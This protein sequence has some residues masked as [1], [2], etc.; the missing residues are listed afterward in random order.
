MIPLK[1]I[2][3]GIYAY[4]QE[5]VIDFQKLTEAQLFGI[6][7][8]VGSGK[9][10]ILE[11]ITF[12][13]YGK[14]ERLG[15]QDNIRH[16]MKNLKS[17]QMFIRFEFLA[18]EDFVQEHCFEVA[19]DGRK[20]SATFKRVQKVKENDRWYQ[21]EL[22]AEKLI[23]LS[24]QNFRR[25][26]IIPQ[27][28]FQEFLQLG[29]TERTRM[30]REIFNLQRFELSQ[31]VKALI[32]KN[33]NHLANILGKLQQLGDIDSEMIAEKT[34]QFAAEKKTL[35]SL[36][37]QFDGLNKTALQLDKLRE[38][39]EKITLQEAKSAQ[40]NAQTADFQQ[41]ETRLTAHLDC[42]AQFK[43]LLEKSADLETQIRQATQELAEMKDREAAE[44]PRLEDRAH[45]FEKAQKDFLQ[46]DQWQQAADELQVLQRIRELTK[47][48]RLTAGE[49]AEVN[50]SFAEK[51]ARIDEKLQRQKKIIETVKQLKHDIPELE[52]LFQLQNWF[53]EA[54]LMDENIQ[55]Q[56][57]QLAEIRESQAGIQAQKTGRLMSEPLQFWSDS[58]TPDTP[59][60]DL[61]RDL[62]AETEQQQT[63]SEKLAEKIH[64]LRVQA[65]LETFANELQPGDPCPLCGATDHP[66]IMNIQN[67]SQ[68]LTTRAAEKKTLDARI[69][70]LREA[71]QF[72][73][74]LQDQQTTQEKLA[75]SAEAE[76]IKLRKKREA[77]RKK[78]QWK[79]FDPEN[80]TAVDEA[81]ETAREARSRLDEMAAEK[82]KLE[83]AIE[84]MRAETEQLSQKLSQLNL[85][86]TNAKTERETLLK[87]LR[88][89]KA[90]DYAIY[91]DAQ[92]KSAAAEFLEKY[93][94][95][96]Q[97]YRRIEREKTELQNFLSRLGGQIQ[98]A[99]QNLDAQQKALQKLEKEIQSELTASSFAD[100]KEV[101]QLLSLNLDAATERR[102]I[103]DFF[104]EK[105]AAETQLA[106][107]HSEIGDKKYNAE[108]HA[109]IQQELAQVS[110]QIDR[111]TR[112]IGSLERELSV[113]RENL[114]TRRSLEKEKTGLENR[115]RN[116]EILRKMFSSSGFVNFVSRIYLQNLCSAANERF[117]RL[118][119]Q[120]LQLELTGDNNFIV[121]DFL[122]GGK[123]RSVKTLSG[124]QT[125]QASLC[126]AL[127][128]ADNVRH[129]SKSAQ[130]FFF[131]DEGFGTLDRESLRLVFETLKSLRKENR[132]IGV[133]SHVE[134]M[135]DEIDVY[136]RIRNDEDKGS[137]ITASWEN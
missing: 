44:K 65:R 136:L 118:T 1:L 133:I 120:Q 113:A 95:V 125:F 89:I 9:S 22:N 19:L 6:F 96:E 27:G 80:P 121:R 3:K 25:T 117:R 4:Q 116:L 101:K 39:A 109:K 53:G 69:A 11:A 132:I 122:N 119:R 42:V 57:K 131:L 78:F 7:G 28:K 20:K 111:Q 48:E 17:D 124:G 93:A 72:F 106:Q 40:L 12:A 79:G 16:N 50:K 43:G 129:L 64:H 74:R 38:L 2:L 62:S 21:K 75:H 13:L 77:H 26:V 18:G 86:L 81:I 104:R 32:S 87:N 91:D 83:K 67:L 36:Q 55:Q 56:E 135:Q 73:Q 102:A 115:G 10:T 112:K 82:A 8:P 68:E 128:L 123:T 23:G 70:V 46:R 34:R 51:T 76:L 60:P 61:L 108:R 45:Q 85:A 134:E 54:A 30:L 41:R 84:E 130:N 103:A 52:E 29:A 58:K 90:D 49:I 71:R 126:L 97:N 63:R 99:T 92:L 94:Q 88:Q 33:E 137:L 14:T 37:K 110:E 98:T 35:K 114:K 100:I 105:H 15:I 66:A 59:L 107:L 47:A 127:A 31:N 24:Y 5:Q